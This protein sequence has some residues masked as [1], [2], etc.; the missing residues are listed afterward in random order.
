MS[1]KRLNPKVKG[2]VYVSLVISIV[3][4]GSECWTMTKGLL[5]KLETFHNKCVRRICRVTT[6]HKIST[7]VLLKRLGIQSLT[8]YYHARLL[9]W[10]GHVARMPMSRLPRLFLTSG[11]AGGTVSSNS[12]DWA[13]TVE[14]ALKA[15]GLPETFSHWGPLAQDRV[16]W[17]ESIKGSMI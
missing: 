16:G 2:S 9:N 14:D 17:M 15:M 12:K 5:Q 4:Y 7:A 6:R 3:L 8:Y 11:I 10:V 1:D 13:W